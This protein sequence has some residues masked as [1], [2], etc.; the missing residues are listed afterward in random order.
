[1]FVGGSAWFQ[2]HV[3]MSNQWVVGIDATPDTWMV[4]VSGHL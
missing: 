1:M 3:S 2:G 4:D